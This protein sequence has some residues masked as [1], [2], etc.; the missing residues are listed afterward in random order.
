MEQK[1]N[2]SRSVLETQDPREVPAASL[3][4]ELGVLLSQF[5]VEARISVKV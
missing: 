5:V 4:Q 1:E 3:G 2:G